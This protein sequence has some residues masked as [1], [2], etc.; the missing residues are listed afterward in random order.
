MPY[1]IVED[2]AFPLKTYLLRPSPG[3][4]LSIDKCIINYRLSRARRISE[5]AFALLA[6]RWRIFQRRINLHPEQCESVVQASCVFHNYL[7]KSTGNSTPT[8]VQDERDG[9]QEYQALQHFT[10]MGCR[11]SSYAYVLRDKFKLYFCMGDGEVSWQYTTVQ[12]GLNRS[13]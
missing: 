1:V 7:Q 11:A 12:R 13:V 4:D 5:N 8:D 6:Q 3:K 9:L 10:N 2:E